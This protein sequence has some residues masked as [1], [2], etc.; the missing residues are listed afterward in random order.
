MNK[1]KAF[2]VISAILVLG[3]LSFY[4]IVDIGGPAT[5]KSASSP[6]V[7]ILEKEILQLANF[8]NDRFCK[9]EYEKIKFHIQEYHTLGKLGKTTT[10]N[11]EWKNNLEVILFAA[12]ADKFITQ[13]NF[14]FIGSEWNVNDLK[15][16]QEETVRLSTS[17]FYV[18]EAP[19][20]LELAKIKSV[21]NKYNEITAFITQ[22]RNFKFLSDDLTA[23]FP[24]SD[25][26]KMI[27][28]SKSLRQAQLGNAKVNNCVRLHQ[29]LKDIPRVLFV[30]HISY[31]RNKIDYWSGKYSLYESQRKYN[32]VLYKPIM[33]ELEAINNDIYGVL[34]FDL[35]QE[36]LVK[37]WKEDGINAMKHKY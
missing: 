9:S 20:A 6:F 21:L 4:L 2:V 35:E 8:S 5:V 32:D 15:F 36:A 12:Y 19:R 31:L 11:N 28:L 22:C 34:N 33:A 17:A 18:K 30:S 3:G 10:E 26:I 37:R 24:I 29:G 7:S 23:R 25:V 16:I 13:A 14:V 1:I 27:S